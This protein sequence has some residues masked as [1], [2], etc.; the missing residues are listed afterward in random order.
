[1]ILHS[2]K[3]F[4]VSMIRHVKH[5]DPKEVGKNGEFLRALSFYGYLFSTMV[6]A[7]IRGVWAGVLF[8]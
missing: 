3:T 5:Q 2:L 8:I 4:I 6:A 7:V 1:M